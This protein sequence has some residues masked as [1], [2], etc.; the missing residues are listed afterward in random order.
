[1]PE[2]GFYED[3][4]TPLFQLKHHLGRFGRVL[5]DVSLHAEDWSFAEA[6]DFLVRE[7]NLKKTHA[8]AEVR[9]ITMYPAQPMC[10]LMGKLE[11]SRIR[12]RYQALRG[13]TRD[14]GELH[15]K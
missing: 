9:R 14:L 4:R 5:S 10:H 6:V 2:K 3:K 15:N 1:M 7:A 12:D 11:I 8:K 13:D